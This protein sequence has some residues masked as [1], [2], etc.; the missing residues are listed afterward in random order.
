M[1]QRLRLVPS[2]LWVLLLAGVVATFIPGA[3][4]RE[5]KAPAPAA[6]TVLEVAPRDVPVSFEYVAQTQSSHL[7]NLQARV[8]GFLE[9]RMDS[10]GDMVKEG[11]VLFQMDAKPF[12]VQLDQA[13]AALFNYELTIQ[14]AFA[15]TENTL[16]SHSKL[17]EQLQAQER[18]VRANREYARLARLQ[19]EGGFAPYSTVLQAEQQLFPAELNEAK[20]RGDLCNSLVNIYKALGGGW[21]TAIYSEK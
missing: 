2:R 17:L 10:E 9:R 3:C 18:L 8:S 1:T 20:S 16:V 12:Q 7:V 4:Q 11:Q 6:V 19:F 21:Q 13:K 5:K 15:D 14:N